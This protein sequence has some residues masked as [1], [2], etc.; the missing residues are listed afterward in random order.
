MA[1]IADRTRLVARKPLARTD[2]LALPFRQRPAVGKTRHAGG[3]GKRVRLHG[4]GFLRD[5]AGNDHWTL[6][7]VGN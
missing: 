4:V 7:R 1:C 6:S 3:A 2:H 5:L